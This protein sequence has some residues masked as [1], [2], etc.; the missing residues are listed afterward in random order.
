M[1]FEISGLTGLA[2][3]PYDM[4]LAAGEYVMI[5]GASGVGKS[6]LLRMI[7]DLDE[8]TEKVLLRGVSREAMP[9]PQWRRQVIYNPAESGG[10]AEDVRRICVRRP[11]R[12][13]Y[14]HSPWPG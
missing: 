5:S 11:R 13:R 14:C 9:A 12:C 2:G 1:Q 8:N 4:S 3:G 6:L 10:W 7:A